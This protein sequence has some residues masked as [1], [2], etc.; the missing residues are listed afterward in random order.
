MEYDDIYV[1]GEG[2]SQDDLVAAIEPL[3]PPGMVVQAGDDFVQDRATAAGAIGGILK[4]ALQA[5][6]LIALF[7]GGFVIV[8]TFTVI[9]RPN[10]CVNW[11]CSLRSAPHPSSSGAR[12]AG[13]VC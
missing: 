11:R 10:G 2:G 6:S 12:F 9:V 5:F 1:L 7:V 3:V 4:R 13:K 8:S